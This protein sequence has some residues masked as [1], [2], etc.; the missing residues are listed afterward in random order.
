MTLGMS[1][2]SSLEPQ[3]GRDDLT[4]ELQVENSSLWHL[5]W[6]SGVKGTYVKLRDSAKKSIIIE[7][8]TKKFDV[9][10]AENQ[11]RF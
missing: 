11:A 3:I 10:I 9:Q 8:T 4:K 1:M 7:I 6:F 5:F 2:I